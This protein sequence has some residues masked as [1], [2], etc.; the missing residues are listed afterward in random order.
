MLT[1]CCFPKTLHESH[2]YKMYAFALS[3]HGLYLIPVP[4]R[5]L[6]SPMES[7][8]HT[9]TFAEILTDHC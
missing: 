7:G 2:P 4:P 6:P 5:L 3:P 8:S 1:D 9:F